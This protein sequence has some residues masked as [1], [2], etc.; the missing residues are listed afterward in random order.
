MSSWRA[1]CYASSYLHWRTPSFKCHKSC[2]WV[3]EEQ[4]EC[5][6]PVLLVVKMECSTLCFL[7]LKCFYST[8]LSTF[9]N[10]L[11]SWTAEW[12]PSA[13]KAVSCQNGMQ[14]VLPLSIVS[15]QHWIVHELIATR[16]S[17]KLGAEWVPS[18]VCCSK[19]TWMQAVPPLHSIW[20]FTNSSSSWRAEWVPW[21]DC[22]SKWTWIQT[23]PPLHSTWLFTHSMSSWGVQ[24]VPSAVG[25][26][27]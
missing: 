5:C 15:L 22:C 11:G 16:R 18:A 20:L 3:R 23:V 8:E 25:H 27:W 7:C 4:N 14:T 21:A 2:H 24:R 1:E 26:C 9:T 12:V 6:Q 19:W 13:V 17:W 10:S